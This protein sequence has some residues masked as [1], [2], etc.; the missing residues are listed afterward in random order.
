MDSAISE[1]PKNS[2][3]ADLYSIKRALINLDSED[4]AIKS[5][6]LEALEKISAD[7]CPGQALALYYLGSYYWQQ[8]DTKKAQ[9]LWAKLPKAQEDK[10]G[11]LASV[12]NMVANRL[13]S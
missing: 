7:S 2:P 6:S 5:K 13:G 9:E 1:L 4:E 11:A 12:R 10:Y 8:G 3:F